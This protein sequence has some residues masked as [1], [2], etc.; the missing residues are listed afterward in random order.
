VLVASSI[1]KAT[2]NPAIFPAAPALCA[3][4]VGCFFVGAVV[5]GGATYYVW[6]QSNGRKIRVKQ[7]TRTWEPGDEVRAKSKQHCENIAKKY[8]KVLVKATPVTDSTGGKWYDC[9][10]R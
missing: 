5:I 1:P 3:T 6:Q 9:T 7:S 8:G 2:A 10:F 4:G